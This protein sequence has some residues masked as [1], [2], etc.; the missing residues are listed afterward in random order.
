MPYIHKDKRSTIDFYLNSILEQ[1][2]DKTCAGD[3]NY[4]LTKIIIAALG[5]N[6]NYDR[7]NSIVGMLECCKLE[8]VRRKLSPY[9]DTKIESNGDVY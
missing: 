2:D 9:E 3:L 5:P 8:L 4:I 1:I 6:P 7:Y